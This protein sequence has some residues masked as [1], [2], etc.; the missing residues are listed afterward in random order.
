[1]TTAAPAPVSAPS[2]DVR[3]VAP[4]RLAVLDYLRLLASLAVVAHHWLFWGPVN[5]MTP[6]IG[7]TPLAPIAAYGYLGVQLFFLISGYVI[8]LSASGRDAGAFAAGRASRLYPAFWA[9]VLITTVA[10]LLTGQSRFPELLPQFLANLTMVPAAFGQQQLDGVYWT[11]T[12]ELEFYA[13]VFLFLA[14]GRRRWLESFFPLWAIGM[15]VTTLFLPA[16]ADIPLCGG[17]FSLFAGGALIAIVGRSGWSILRAVGLAASLVA[18]VVATI[19]RAGGPEAIGVPNALLLAGL[20]VL[21]YGLVFALTTRRVA[22]VRLPGSR[23]AGG[24]T[25]PLYLCHAAFGYTLLNLIATPETA[26]ASYAAVFVIVL[27]VALLVHLLVER[28]AAPVW[29]KLFAVVLAAPVRAA[30]ALAARAANRQS[31]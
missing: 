6:G 31:R 27:A 25:Y 21:F 11:L 1:M 15:L 4:S 7:V 3:T 24:L 12:L 13:L 23:L 29:R 18:A 16:V 10:A 9:G 2:S 14:F 28:A 17:L 8:F 20:V 22:A 26:W 30:A 5:G 19:R